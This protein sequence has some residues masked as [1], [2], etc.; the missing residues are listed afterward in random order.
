MKGQ[1][2]IEG[3]EDAALCSLLKVTDM[4]ERCR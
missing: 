3:E 1:T 2:Q 4:S